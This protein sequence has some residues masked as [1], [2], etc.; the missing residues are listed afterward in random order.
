[1]TA[2]RV[3]PTPGS[4]GVCVVLWHHESHHGYINQSHLRMWVVK[5]GTN[6]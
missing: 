1:M 6:K 3:S 4:V 5:E 2:M